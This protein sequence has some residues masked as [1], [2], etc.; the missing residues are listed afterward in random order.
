MNCFVLLIGF[1]SIF[2]NLE[3]DRMI[4]HA[5]TMTAWTNNIMGC[6]KNAFP[7]VNGNRISLSANE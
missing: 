3:R 1:I 6:C 4:I 2:K 7:T 5:V